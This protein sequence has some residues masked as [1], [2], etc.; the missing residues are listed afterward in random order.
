MSRTAKLDWVRAGQGLLRSGGIGA[1]KVR[2]LARLLGVT[3]GS[4]YHHFANFDAF[5]DELAARFAA[6]VEHLEAALAERSPVERIGTL[7]AIRSHAEVP[8]LDRAMRIWADSD[9]RARSAVTSLDHAVLRLIE[10]AFLDLG[11]DRAE[12]RARACTA[13][14]AG[15]GLG[16]MAAPWPVGNDEEA[17]SVALFLSGAPVGPADGPAAAR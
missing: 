11:F 16:M 1:V 7:L 8:A 17:R 10:R 9:E 3:T 2:D 13:Y 15:I 4:F 5:L 14:A 12:A 6:D